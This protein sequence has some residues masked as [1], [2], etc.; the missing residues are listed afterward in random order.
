MVA[1]NISIGPGVSIG[2]GWS[3][4]G[5]TSN[6]SFTITSARLSNPATYGA[7]FS[8][9]TTSGF[10]IDNPNVGNNLH[11]AYNATITDND[12]DI[13]AAFTAAGELSTPEYPAYIWTVAWGPGSTYTNLAQVGYNSGV[14]Q[15]YMIPVDPASPW[16][17]PGNSGYSL[18]GTFTFPATFTAYLPP[19]SKGG[20]C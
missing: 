2:P 18:A 1:Y 12:S 6:S 10:T 3:L 15:I 13:I 9:V 7:T 14:K 17:T 5:N 16:S 8:G 4:G 11:P 20:W 19:I